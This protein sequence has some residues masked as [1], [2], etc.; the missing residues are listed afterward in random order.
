MIE[1][2]QFTS[3]VFCFMDYLYGEGTRDYFKNKILSI[4]C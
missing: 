1:I 4:I 2:M 3:F